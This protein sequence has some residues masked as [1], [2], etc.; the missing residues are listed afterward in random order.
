MTYECIET[1]SFENY[2][3]GGDEAAE[4]YITVPV[5]SI[6]QKTGDSFIGG[7]IHLHSEND[8]SW[9]EISRNSL[10]KYFRRVR[11]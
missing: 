8:L 2:C 7:E 1:F 9:I 5:G 11:E 10:A 4:E 3:F 6:W